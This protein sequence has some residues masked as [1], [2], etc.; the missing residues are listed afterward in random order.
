MLKI[1]KL[2]FVLSAVFCLNACGSQS[3][4]ITTSANELPF[5]V[6]GE[7]GHTVVSQINVP[8]GSSAK[9][10]W[11]QINNLSYDDKASVQINNGAWI[12]LRNDNTEIEA[13]GK[14]YGGI[15]GGYSSLRLSL[16]VS[17]V[18]D[19]ANTLRF[20]FNQSDGISIGYRVLA[21]NLLDQNGNKL[22]PETAFA[23][24]DPNNWKPLRDN[25]TDISQGKSLW[26]GADLKSSYQTN[27]LS[28]R[29]HC[30]ECHA[31]DGRDLHQFNYSSYSIVERA[32]FHGLSQ[33]QG[34]QISSYIRSLSSQFGVPG[35]LCR[36]WN[37]PYQPGIGL[38]AAPVKD[39]SCGA[40][41]EAVLENDTDSLKYVFPNGIN[42]TA[43]D[44]KGLLNAREIPVAFQLPDW[45][46]W[47]P[48]VHPKDAWGDYFLNSNLNKRYAGEGTGSDKI[49][50]RDRLT[51]GGEAYASGKQGDFWNDLYY[52][53]VEWGERFHP[54]VPAGDSIQDQ[55]KVYSTAQ[56]LVVKNWELA[57][58]FKLEQ[59]C[60]K[61]YQDRVALNPAIQTNK[62]EM[63]SWC[64]HWRFVFDVSPHILKLPETN[65]MFGSNNARTYFANAWYYLQLLINP[66]SGAHNVHLPTD[67]QYAYGLLNDLQKVSS[68]RE[69]V[70]SLIYSVKGMQEMANGIDVSDMN[71]G[72]NF[73]DASPL[74]VWRDGKTGVWQGVPDATRQAAV[75]AYLETWLERSEAFPAA[76][77]Q[78]IDGTDG[79]NWCGWSERRL[80]WSD[81]VPGIM[82]GTNPTRENFASWSF[83]AIPEMR[84]DGIDGALLNRYAD[85]MNRLYPS[86]GFANL[87]SN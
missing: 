25:P 62:V 42:K 86:A 22:I 71:K 36:P 44:A 13:A 47:L 76:N 50:L 46:H 26:Y 7:E 49:V 48:R 56:W 52:W 69:P 70:R 19:G 60:P 81:F 79:S 84:S 32:K 24:T 9:R 77:W 12:N 1:L 74:D 39:W 45:K 14:A 16:G 63:R 41:L 43:I 30:S 61:L 11:L 6:L 38:D 51:S 66:G 87:N 15:G 40:G 20:R 57:Q 33:V 17:D 72:W 10:L 23:H 53:G 8:Q 68:R 35:K 5:E 83:G 29:A 18:M 65:S 27:A 58:E 59:N 82:R 2:T 54:P 28:I 67:W 3:A 75:N 80:C 34:E 85:L 64:G 73:R 78:R 55:T 37:P 21:F 4:P 31:Q